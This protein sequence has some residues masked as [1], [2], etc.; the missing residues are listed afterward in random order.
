M[1]KITG[2]FVTSTVDS[3]SLEVNYHVS[4]FITK[5]MYEEL[6]DA[7][8]EIYKNIG[9]LECNVC[10]MTN[11]KI[12]TLIEFKCKSI[13]GIHYY[14]VPID[15]LMTAS[16]I[17]NR[18][19]AIEHLESCVEHE[20]KNILSDTELKLHSILLK[21][22]DLKTKIY[23]AKQEL[24]HILEKDVNSPNYAEKLKQQNIKLAE[25]E[26]CRGRLIGKYNHIITDQNIETKVSY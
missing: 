26:N 15:S 3:F 14:D 4:T 21:Q 12:K 18:V 7:A 23:Y 6:L 20:K 25:L 10:F 17:E 13:E 2:Y 9:Y 1:S 19:E 24:E 5:S 22:R 11:F 8:T 16:S